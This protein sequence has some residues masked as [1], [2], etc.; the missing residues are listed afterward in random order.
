[1]TDGTS[2]TVLP[3]GIGV[4]PMLDVVAPFD[5]RGASSNVRTI[6]CHAQ[7]GDFALVM[8]AAG[9]GTPVPIPGFGHHFELDLGSLL[10]LTNLVADASGTAKL[11]LPSIAY[12]QPL[13]FQALV[14]RAP[15][16]DRG[17]FTNALDV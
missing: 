12:R 13:R 9:P 8:L 11:S 14:L 16:F 1:M 10:V 7:A 4:E 2:T 5:P 3:R 15:S 6:L 17:S